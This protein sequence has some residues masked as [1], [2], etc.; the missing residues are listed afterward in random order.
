[1]FIGQLLERLRPNTGIQSRQ[2]GIKSKQV[3]SA[4]QDITKRPLFQASKNL[5]STKELNKA[6]REI[7]NNIQDKTATHQQ[8]LLKAEILLR[9][10]KFRKSKEILTRISNDKKNQSS[11]L[12]AK[13]LLKILPQLREEAATNK[14]KKLIEDLRKI[15][16]KYETK[17]LSLPSND[18]LLPRL[19]ITILI[20][21]ESRLAR[22]AELPGLSL[23][24]I[25]RTLQDVQESLWLRHDKALS[26]NM[27]GQQQTALKLLRELK[28]TT[29]N[30]K[31]TNSI[32]RNIEDIQ[33]HSKRYQS[34]LN[35]YLAK[36]SKIM[37]KS[38]G[39]DATFLP[40][41]R[42]IS[43]KSRIKFLVFRK[44][45]AILTENP[46]ACLCLA[47]SILDYFRDDLAAILL[48]GE[49]LAALKKDDEAVDIW[50]SLSRSKDENIA[51][52]ASE[53]ISQ[54][55]S[56]KAIR[57]SAKESP[58]KALSFF[59]HQHLKHSITPTINKNIKKILQQLEPHDTHF[60]DPDLEQHQLQLLFNTQLIECLETRFREQNRLGSTSPAQKPGTIRKTAPKAG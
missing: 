42:T 3:A 17:L 52:K 47:N 50:K 6:L 15:A 54:S 4:D 21:K 18:D 34:K 12:N 8:L 57:M 46:K 53:L 41:E 44:A 32:D 40:E 19:D 30:E 39:L 38:N 56:K 11:S 2:K 48:K 35:L 1:M 24:L 5:N 23:E 60:S 33:K 58:K 16:Q 20:R 37:I 7:D 9:V 43:E 14:T 27:M 36:Q 25:D 31:I 13:H 51:T 28:E 49:A 22:S 45:R 10:G 29:K 55:L 59:I 26:I